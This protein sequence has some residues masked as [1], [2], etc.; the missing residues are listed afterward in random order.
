MSANRFVPAVN[1]PYA[2]IC[3]AL[4]GAEFHASTLNRSRTGELL[5]PPN[6]FVASIL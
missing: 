1:I 2:T 6:I 4:R 3:R 5:S